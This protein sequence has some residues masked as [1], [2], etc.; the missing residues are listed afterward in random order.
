MN[1]KIKRRARDSIEKLFCAGVNNFVE[2][3]GSACAC[4][5]HC[6]KIRTNQQRKLQPTR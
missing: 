3:V 4:N 5:K 2:A 6:N 1:T